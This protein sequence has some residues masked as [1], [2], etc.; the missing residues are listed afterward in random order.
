MREICICRDKSSA[1]ELGVEDGLSKEK[2]SGLIAEKEDL[3]LTM[4][5]L[6]LTFMAGQI[7]W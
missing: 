3:L 1:E 5:T 4:A 7:R 6:M 2:S